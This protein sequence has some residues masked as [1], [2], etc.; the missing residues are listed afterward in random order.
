MSPAYKTSCQ[1]EPQCLKRKEAGSKTE[2]MM[3]LTY[4]KG[5]LYSRDFKSLPDGDETIVRYLNDRPAIDALQNSD[6][7][8]RTATPARVEE[9]KTEESKGDENTKNSLSTSTQNTDLKEL[10]L[11]DSSTSSTSTS[12]AHRL[13]ILKQHQHDAKLEKL[14]ERIRKQW[15][16]PEELSSR[17]QHVECVEHPVMVAATDNAVTPKVRKVATAPPA[18]SYKGT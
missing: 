13:D 6:P 12:S 18:P 15:E 7:F 5:D 1:L 17:G 3:G 10:Q 16:Q 9:E 14:K 11:T 8:F 4:D 2:G